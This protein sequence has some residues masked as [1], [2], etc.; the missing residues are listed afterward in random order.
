MIFHIGGFPGQIKY[1]FRK[2]IHAKRF[3]GF[4]CQYFVKIPTGCVR[5]DLAASNLLLGGRNFDP[6]Y[7]GGRNM[8]MQ[9]VLTFRPKNRRDQTFDSNS[10]LDAARTLLTPPFRILKKI[11]R[12]EPLNFLA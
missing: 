3:I 4:I 7:F 12:S 10:R 6:F 9:H 1:F 5:K 2:I 8:K 11:L